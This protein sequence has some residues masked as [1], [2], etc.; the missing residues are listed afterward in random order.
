MLAS[1]G[2]SDLL[3]FDLAAVMEALIRV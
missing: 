1:S 3:I 2:G